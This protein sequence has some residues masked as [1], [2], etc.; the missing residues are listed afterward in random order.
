MSPC[1]NMMHPNDANGIA[2]SLDPD[3]T[4]P[5][6]RMSEMDYAYSCPAQLQKK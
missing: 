2:N 6:P 1:N 5:T 3:Q 4:A